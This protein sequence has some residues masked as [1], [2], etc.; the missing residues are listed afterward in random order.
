MRRNLQVDGAVIGTSQK[1]ASPGTITRSDKER[2]GC[3]CPEGM[4]NLRQC[5]YADKVSVKRVC[6][7]ETVGTRSSNH[8]AEKGSGN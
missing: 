8:L 6:G 7:G 3:Y 1:E 5:H 4:L 2:R